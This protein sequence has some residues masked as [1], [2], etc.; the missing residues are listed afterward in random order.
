M[1]IQVLRQYVYSET[2]PELDENDD[3]VQLLHLAD[4][5][6]LPGL[7][8]AISNSMTRVLTKSNCLDWLIKGRIKK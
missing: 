7:K 6:L 3:F 4:Y 2:T 8:K 1:L 5:W